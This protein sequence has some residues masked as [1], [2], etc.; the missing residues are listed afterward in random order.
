MVKVFKLTTQDNKTRKGK[1]NER[2]WG[3]RVTH[4]GTGEGALCGPGYIH[5]YLSPVLAVLL[6]PI[7]AN[8]VNPKLWECSVKAIAKNGNNLKIGA[9]AL[10]TDREIDIPLVSNDQRVIFAILCAER[11]QEIAKT[12]FSGGTQRQIKYFTN[13]AKFS[14]WADAFKRGG[15]IRKDQNA[16]ADAARAADA[17]ANT[18]AAD[19]ADAADAAAYAARAARASADAAYVAYA[20]S[21]AADVAAYADAG[22][23][24]NTLDLVAIA[25]EAISFS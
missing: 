1:Y 19:A 23:R 2:T 14:E 10:T 13:M 24:P 12:V 5:A 9:V 22:G 25:E 21:L 17:A 6:N 8:I 20:A 3:P 11:A 16:A 7:H 4:S 15:A 18:C